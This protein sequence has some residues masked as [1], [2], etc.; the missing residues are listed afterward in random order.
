MQGI[1]PVIVG[2][3]AEWSEAT[4]AACPRADQVRDVGNDPAKAK[5]KTGVLTP[6]FFLA[7]RTLYPDARAEGTL[8]RAQLGGLRR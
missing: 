1:K 4:R 7:Y 5:K 3:M 8:R 2:L 6:F